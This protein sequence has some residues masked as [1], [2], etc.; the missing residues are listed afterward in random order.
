MTD[1]WEYLQ[2][3]DE[4]PAAMM[5]IDV[6]NEWGKQGWELCMAYAI[7]TP[8]AVVPG[9]VRLEPGQAVARTSR[10]YVYKRKLK[11]VQP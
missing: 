11:E 2:V 3:H 9:T 8:V 10:V 1:K 7:Q 5:D 4:A 6:L